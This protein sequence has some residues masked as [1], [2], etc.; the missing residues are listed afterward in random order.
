MIANQDYWNQAAFDPEPESEWSGPDALLML[1]DDPQIIR[2]ASRVNA[3]HKGQRNETGSWP[4]DFRQV[5]LFCERAFARVF[6]TAMDTSVKRFGSGRR[7]AVLNNGMSIDVI[8]RR[9]RPDKS[10]PDL[11]RKVSGYRQAADACVLIVWV[12]RGW[13]P[14]FLGWIR[15]YEVKEKGQIRSFQKGGQSYVVD[16]ALLRPMTELMALQ[17]TNDPLAQEASL[18]IPQRERTLEVVSE[19]GPVQQKITLSE[20]DER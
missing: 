5:G 13:E 8:G 10:L 15:D 6:R 7:N 20:F 1:P 17:R 4:V 12:G 9:I 3:A 11:T 2:L 14:V 19:P 18:F 16:Q